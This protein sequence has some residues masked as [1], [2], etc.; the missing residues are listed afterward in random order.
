LMLVDI[1][2]IFPEMFPGV[3]HQSMLKRAQDKDLLSIRLI[4][5]RDFTSDRHRKVDDVPYGGGPGMVLKAEPLDRALYYAAQGDP[6]AK[7]VYMT[8]QGKIFSQKMAEEFSKEKHLVL[9]CGHYEGIDQRIRDSVIDLEISIGD[10]VLT[11]GELAALVVLDAAVRLIPGVLG[12]EESLQCESFTDYLLDYPQYTRP[13]SFKDMEVPE[14]L[15]SGNHEKIRKWRRQ[16]SL[17]RTLR[18]R[19]DQFRKIHL[20]DEDIEL[21]KDSS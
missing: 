1:I 7:R 14:V 16:Q 19:P 20:T 2:T 10:Y 9:V 8:P 6:K 3:I 17:R 5:L 4:D 11:G 18:E 13:A 21:L 15:L 12:A